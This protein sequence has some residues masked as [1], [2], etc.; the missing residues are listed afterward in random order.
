[1]TTGVR[2]DPYSNFRFHVEIN[3]ITY[4]MFRECTGFMSEIAITENPQGGVFETQKLPGRVKYSNIVLK[5]GLTDSTD[6]YKWHA[7]AIKGTIVRKNGSIRVLD[8]LGQEKVRW[9]FVNGWPSKYDAP[10]FNASSDD[11]AIETL[12]IAIERLERG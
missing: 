3:G 1:M 11:I 6:L 8:S 4:G 9:N 7:D 12:E 10:D 5:W 2:V